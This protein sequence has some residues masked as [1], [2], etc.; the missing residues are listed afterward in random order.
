MAFYLGIDIGTSSTKTL[1]IN[2]RGEAIAESSADYP[3]LTPKPG[4]TE[5]D[6]EAW[7]QATVKTV[8][9]VMEKGGLRPTDVRAIGLS[10]SLNLSCFNCLRNASFL[11]YQD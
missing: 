4:W 2:E 7:W 5:Q 9:A 10:I 1:L 3:V 8:R 11:R 6:P